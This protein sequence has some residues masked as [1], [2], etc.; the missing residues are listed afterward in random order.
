MRKEIKNL[1]EKV[2]EC[3]KE[4]Y[5]ELGS[6]WEEDVYQKAMEV[7][8]RE[9]GIK[10]EAQRTLPISFRGFVVGKGFPDLIVWHQKDKKKI[11]IVVELNSVKE[12]NLDS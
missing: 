12:I 3:A 8:L 7:V 1:I 11:A 4:A 6:G 2:K 9:K 5:Q 10:Y